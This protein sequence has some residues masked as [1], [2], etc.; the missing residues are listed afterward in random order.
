MR[1]DGIRKIWLDELLQ[2]KGIDVDEPHGRYLQPDKCGFSGTATNDV[3]GLRNEV[4][5]L[6]WL[7]ID[8]AMGVHVDER[9]VFFSRVEERR[10]FEEIVASLET[11]LSQ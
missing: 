9:K 7:Q 6:V 2:L 8:E 4:R 3:W 10:D 1:E 11:E 5:R